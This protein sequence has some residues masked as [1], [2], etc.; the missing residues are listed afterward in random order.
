ITRARRDDVRATALLNFKYL[1][2]ERIALDYLRRVAA[3]TD[4]TAGRAAEVLVTEMG[5]EGLAV[6]REMYLAREAKDIDVAA[7]LS[8]RQTRGGSKGDG[9]SS[10]RLRSSARGGSRVRWAG[11]RCAAGGPAGRRTAGPVRWNPSW[12]GRAR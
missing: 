12:R 7:H 2:D 10:G 9:T 3:S 8:L 4:I 1:E 11:A 6:L 5:P